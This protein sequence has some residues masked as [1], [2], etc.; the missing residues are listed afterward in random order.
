[1]VAWSLDSNQTFWA[2]FVSAMVFGNR[3]AVAG[4]VA[5]CRMMSQ[6]R[7]AKSLYRVP[8]EILMG[9]GRR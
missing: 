8:A 1:M 5:G 4:Q 7:F 6:E 3:L 2:G 9:D